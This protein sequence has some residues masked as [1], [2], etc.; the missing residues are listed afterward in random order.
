MVSVILIGNDKQGNFT[1]SFASKSESVWRGEYFSRFS[2]A[3]L[4]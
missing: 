4:Q 2:H 1:L 3:L